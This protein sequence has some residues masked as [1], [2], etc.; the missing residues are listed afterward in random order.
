MS[1]RRI[2]LIR[3]D[4]IGLKGKNRRFFEN[5]LLN[6]IRSK[7]TGLD[8]IRYRVPRGR[9]LIDIN[10][11]QEEESVRRLHYIPGIASFSVG[12][13]M[14]PDFDKVAELGIQWVEPL[15]SSGKTLTFCV[16]TQRSDKR[17][18]V[19][20]PEFSYQVGSRVLQRLSEK[21]LGVDLVNAEFVLE[22]EIGYEETIV[23]RNRIPGLRGLPV[24]TAGNVLTLLSGGI[25]SPVAAF[26]A[27]RRGCRSHFVFFDNRSFLGRGGY[28]KV[29]KLSGIVNRY[30]G[31]G[32]LYVVPFGDIQVSIRDHCRPA[33]R[34]VLY[35]RMMYRLAQAIAE[36][37]R[38]L[39]LV[40]GES[41]G[42]VAS[43]TL[44]NLAA[45]SCVVSTSVFRPVI[46]MDKVDIIARAR[47]IGTYDISIEPSPDC[48]SVFMPPSPA[49]R[50]KIGDLEE[51]ERSYPW[52]DLMR[53]AIEN[54]QT[55][56]L[57]GSV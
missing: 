37:H 9:I 17:F 26:M 13:P 44:E 25:D 28:D 53:E 36:K 32:R 38:Y 20:S 46:A 4:E 51:D 23:F 27:I 50:S 22:I 30:Q 33:N 39:A 43:Q 11:A 8:D 10:Q 6:Q 24:G 21:G 40:T 18:P 57:D 45:V 48:C 56:D 54:L 15:L 14:E 35:R 31:G 55:T 19:T 12:T 29:L 1:D 16:R 52:Q 49:T 3:Y 2:I 7:L 47:R 34:I 5:C 42:Q 41:I